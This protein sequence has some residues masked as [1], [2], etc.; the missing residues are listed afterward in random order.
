MSTPSP[1]A[2]RGLP[3]R[4][5]GNRYHDKLSNRHYVG[6]VSF[7]LAFS[8]LLHISTVTIFKIIVYIPM[9]H[10][11]YMN[12]QLVA[13]SRQEEGAETGDILGSGIRLPTLELAQYERLRL[14]SDA[15]SS[16][17][18]LP[19][20]VEEDV[21]DSWARFSGALQK[22]GESISD[23]TLSLRERQPPSL[24][25]SLEEDRPEPV[26]RP[27]EGFEIYIEWNADTK[28]DLLFVPS[29]NMLWGRDPGELV[30]PIEV[31][32]GVDS[33]GRIVNALN[34]RLD[35]GELADAIQRAVL[36]FRFAPR[37]GGNE[38]VIDFAT[39]RLQAAQE[40]V[41]P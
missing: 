23:L 40:E 4:R 36:N 11:N 6:R 17:D 28:R 1:E 27:A 3:W 31:V 37:I 14:S 7:A 34:P 33:S 26:L 9:S 41:R 38:K 25:L 18:E 12:V 15:L 20:P 8:T 16:L 24:D 39:I 30:R 10:P 19:L 29:M 13:L 5:R 35:E 2:V 21:P 22:A 32:A